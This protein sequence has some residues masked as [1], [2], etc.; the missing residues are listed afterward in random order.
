MANRLMPQSLYANLRAT[1]TKRTFEYN[2]ERGRQLFGQLT[3]KPSRVSIYSGHA[4]LDGLAH[5]FADIISRDRCPVEI[6]TD[7][8]AADIRLEMVP[9][10]LTTPSTTIYSLYHQLGVDSVTTRPANEHIRRLAAELRFVESPRRPSDYYRHLDIAGRIMSEELGIFPL[11]Q[12]TL[13]LHSH[14]RLQGVSFD[15][16]GR[17]DFSRAVLID[18]PQPDEAVK[19]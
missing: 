17:I 9:S 12:P 10:S 13:F 4:T 7:W 14:Q 11:F 2:A 5:Y 16:D 8:R 19:R 6:V 1:P 3:Y 15:T 18:L